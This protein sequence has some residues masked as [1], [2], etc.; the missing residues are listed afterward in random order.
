MNKKLI[1][2]LITIGIIVSGCGSSPAKSDSIAV[3]E[4]TPTVA[5]PTETPAPTA[6]PVPTNTPTPTPEP[7]KYKFDP[8]PYVP[9]LANDIPQ[10][11]WDSFYN[12]CD[13]IRVGETTF[14]CSSEEAYKWATDVVT[15]TELIP[16]ACTKIKGESNDGTKPY[17]NGIGRIYYQMPIDEYVKRQAQFESM[18]EDVLNK[19]LEPDDDEFEKCLKLYDYMATEYTYDYEFLEEMPDG[20][21]YLTI[22]NKKGQCLELASVYAYFLLQAGVEAIGVGCYKTNM[23]H[24]WTYVIVNGKGYFSDPTWALKSEMDTDELI[25]Y[26]F[27]MTGEK[28][29]QTG[30]P[31]DDISGP[32]IPGYWAKFASV[33][34]TAT[35]DKYDFPFSSVFEKLDEKNKV[36]YYTSL[37]DE[38]S[39]KYG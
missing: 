2:L 32:L 20:A 38:C 31:V 36:I 1:A 33:E 23:N 37:D 7:P 25:L 30:C 5:P 17:E 35:D 24:E 3:P 29:A 26:Y 21:N 22:I 13:A 28:R 12:L 34:I 9:M 8:H 27:M 11:H 4:A 16:C 10:D 18:V 15:L 14:K 6:T 39:L 19:Y